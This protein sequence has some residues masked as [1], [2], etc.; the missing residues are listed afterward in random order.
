MCSVRS[1][2]SSTGRT[3][4]YGYPV[5]GPGCERQLR[6]YNAFRY[7]TIDQYANPNPD[8][9]GGSQPDGYD[10]RRAKRNADRHQQRRH[11]TDAYSYYRRRRYDP[12]AD[13]N[14]YHRSLDQ[15]ADSHHCARFAYLYC[16]DRARPIGNGDALMH[17][18]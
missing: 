5:Y 15:H 18:A 11:N 2:S 1:I 7:A 13:L 8:G 9:D 6:G 14:G 12:H 17:Y 10:R 4:R 3:W 16:Y